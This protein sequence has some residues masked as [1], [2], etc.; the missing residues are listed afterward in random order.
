MPSPAWPRSFAAWRKALPP[1]GWVQRAVLCACF[2]LAALPARAHDDDGPPS[3]ERAS[4]GILAFLVVW[5]WLYVVVRIT[6]SRTHRRR[7]W[8]RRRIKV[9]RRR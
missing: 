6:A 4:V 7:Y 2:V 3:R 1:R 8:A 9:R 5:I